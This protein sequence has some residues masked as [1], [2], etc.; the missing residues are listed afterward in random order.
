MTT[1]LN[2]GDMVPRFYNVI[3]HT[4]HRMQI[5]YPRSMDEKQFKKHLADL[6]HGHHHP[7][8]HDWNDD[9]RTVPDIEAAPAGTARARAKKPAKAKAVKKRSKK[10]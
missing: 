2:P 8:E 9:T 5:R 1:S 10:K 6:A 3:S 7:E 4:D